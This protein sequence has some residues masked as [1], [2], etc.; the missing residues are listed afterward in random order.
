M[1]TILCYGDSLIWGH[2]VGGERFSYEETIPAILQ[3]LLSDEYLVVNEGLRSR[4]IN[5]D[6]DK[7]TNRNGLVYFPV[8]LETYDPI[9]AVVIM[10]GTN[11]TKDRFQKIADEMVVG[12]SEYINIIQGFPLTN[13]KTVPKIILCIP[14]MISPQFLRSTSQFSERS[15]TLL[16]EYAELL[17][18]YSSE[19]KITRVD[20]SDISACELDGVHL[21]PEI[22]TDIAKRIYNALL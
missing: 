8:A 15:N 9:S 22:N 10:L 20:C 18:L 13:S 5:T 19:H 16:Q 3:S 4:T 12:I 6:D 1:K 17:R 11:D 7:Q 2:R 14:P 21:S